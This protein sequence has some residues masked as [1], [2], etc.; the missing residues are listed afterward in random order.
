MPRHSAAHRALGI[1]VCLVALLAF[2]EAAAARGAKAHARASAAPAHG[3]RAGESRRNDLPAAVSAILRSSGLPASSF[4]FDV[5]PVDGDGRASLVA[6]H[7]E[8]P[9]LLAS[10]TKVVTSLAALDLLG[11]EHRWRTSAYATGPVVGGRLAGNLVIVGGTVGLTGSE[12]R[13]WFAQMRSE[14]VR[15]IAGDIVLDDVALLH[16]LDPKQAADT[17]AERAPDAPVDARTY[18][19][20]KLLVTVRPGAGDRAVVALKPSP[21]NVRV[22]ND[23][24][25]GGGCAA[26]A[27]W[28]TADEIGSGP[29]L[30]LWVRGRWRADCGADDIAYVAP[31][32]GA[33]FGPELGDS[34]TQSI[35]A[36]RMVA[37]LWAE[38]GGSLQGHVVVRDATSRP[39]ASRWSSELL[40][41]VGEV[42][43]E[44]NKTS[45][46]EAAR[47]VLLSL[48]GTGDGTEGGLRVG[49]LKAAQERMRGWLR[50][51]G[52]HAGDITVVLGSGQSRA[53][54]GKPRALVDLLR[55]AWHSADS[56]T[57]LDS[58]PIAGVDGTLVHRMTHGAATGQ[59][60]LK[61]GTL[62]DTRA[63]AGYVRGRSGTVYA[64]AAIVTHPEARRGLPTLDAL[65]EW[66]ARER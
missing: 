28:K 25:M 50:G 11:P 37:E 23:V 4:A 9:F 43:R 64:V 27:R 30:Q 60:Y 34:R 18:N 62:S 15:T 41:P 56:Q 21:V 31:P 40:T 16:E 29:P 3:A 10:T 19:L 57:L 54:R 1:A 7:A 13:R 22:V 49:A 26:W 2:P 55:N 61:T 33:R 5:R 58:L 47:S 35:A 52:L 45:N 42:L 46:N 12:L 32:E 66:L 44:M 8:Q 14:G 6:Y 39:R 53:E 51:Q 48:A 20:G 17:A 36:P 24:A 59:A 65:I 63:L 38:A